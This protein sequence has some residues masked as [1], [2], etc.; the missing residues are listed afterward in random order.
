MLSVIDALQGFIFHQNKRTTEYLK[1]N[2]D[3]DEIPESS[4]SF[5]RIMNMKK[6][7]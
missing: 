3:R 7:T 2:Y 5:A 4:K 1:I 6:I